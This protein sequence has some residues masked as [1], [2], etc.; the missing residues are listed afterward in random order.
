MERI[1]EI[2]YKYKTILCPFFNKVAE[3]AVVE[4]LGR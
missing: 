3:R 2:K 1:V 4:V